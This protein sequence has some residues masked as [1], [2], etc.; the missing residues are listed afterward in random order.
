M[1]S[2]PACSFRRRRPRG[3]WYPTAPSRRAVSPE[4]HQWLEAPPPPKLPPPPEQ[5]PPLPPLPHP[6]PRRPPPTPPP[7]TPPNGPPHHP[8]RLDSRRAGAVPPTCLPRPRSRAMGKK[9]SQTPGSTRPS[10][11]K[12]EKG[13]MAR[14][15]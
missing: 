11:P 10:M 7:P 9:I 15:G 6:P 8:P 5:P 14:K 1:V 12:N 2:P 3:R 4:R 13:K